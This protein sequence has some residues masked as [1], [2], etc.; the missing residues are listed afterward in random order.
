MTD[1]P[2]IAR[3]LNRRILENPSARMR[4]IQEFY[5]EKVNAG[6][7]DVADFVL[8]LRSITMP[9]PNDQPPPK[10][11]QVAG[12]IT[13]ILVLLFFMS[14]VGMNVFGHPL[15]DTSKFP[16]LIIFSFGAG[17]SASFL[18]GHASMS[19]KIPFFADS[20]LIVAASGGI[21]VMFT[22]LVLGYYFYIK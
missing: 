14:V 11:P 10:W 12:F 1:Y 5:I 18:T 2:A 8:T 4:I 13:G 20:P 9:N 22:I 6:E 7:G 19:G 3:E 15:P 21:A 17:L 16:L